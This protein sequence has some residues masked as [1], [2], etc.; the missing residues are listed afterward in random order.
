MSKAKVHV[1]SDTVLFLGQMQEHSEAKEK[2][3]DQLQ[4]FRH[5]NGYKE[6]FGSDGEPIELEWNIVPGRTT[7]Q[8]LKEIQDRVAVRQTCP[9]E[10][11]DRIIFMSMFNDIDWIKE[12]TMYV[13]RIL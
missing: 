6:L 9:E 2:W 3:Q 11:E 5:S 7:K 8:I 4:Y 12:I 10:L 1:N 13:F